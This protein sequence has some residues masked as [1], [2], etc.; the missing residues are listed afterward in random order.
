MG[1]FQLDPAKTRRRQKMTSDTRK[2]R[3]SPLVKEMEPIYPNSSPIFYT[4]GCQLAHSALHKRGESNADSAPASS[5]RL[6][7]A[8]ARYQTAHPRMTSTALPA[9]GRVRSTVS[10]TIGEHDD[11]VPVRYQK[12]PSAPLSRLFEIDET[13]PVSWPSSPPLVQLGDQSPARPS[14]RQGGQQLLRGWGCFYSFS[15]RVEP[16][17]RRTWC[18]II[19]ASKPSHPTLFSVHPS[20]R[21]PG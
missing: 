13:A 4:L 15:Q 2:F 5:R 8:P 16:R 1:C 14:Q 9:T 10:R 20:A 17:H 3:A 11:Q 18:S 21:K 7:R 19:G 12:R 6:S